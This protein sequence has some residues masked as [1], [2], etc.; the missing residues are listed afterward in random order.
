M[1]GAASYIISDLDWDR[2]EAREA[3]LAWMETFDGFSTPKERV[4]EV[5]RQE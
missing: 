4:E 5:P 3:T 1:F 2:D